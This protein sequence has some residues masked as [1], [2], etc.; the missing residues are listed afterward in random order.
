MFAVENLGYNANGDIYGWDGTFRGTKLNPG[1]YAYYIIYQADN[2]GK[3]I[4]TGDVT[5]IK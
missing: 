2:E 4:K 3:K 1:V 5:L